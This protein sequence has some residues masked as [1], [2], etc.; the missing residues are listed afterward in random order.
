MKPCGARILRTIQAQEASAE[1]SELSDV[2]LVRSPAQI[3]R[4]RMPPF[5]VRYLE[6]G[7]S[8]G[9]PLCS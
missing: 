1:G 6:L 5:V 3:D 4:D 8:R 7:F 9:D 2:I